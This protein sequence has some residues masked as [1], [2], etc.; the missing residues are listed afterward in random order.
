[1]ATVFREPLAYGPQQK[2]PIPAVD[3]FSRPL[4]LGINPNAKFSQL[5]DSA[6][7][8]RRAVNS[9]RYP[10]LLLTTLAGTPAVLSLPLQSGRSFDS[11][12]RKAWQAD[13]LA[14]QGFLVCP[15]APAQ[16]LVDSAPHARRFLGQLQP[17][18]LL[19]STLAVVQTAP[20]G[21]AVLESAPQTR[22]RLSVDLSQDLLGTTLLVTAATPQFAIRL[23]A[24]APQI[25]YQVRTEALYRPLT[26]GINPNA[27]ALSI[28]DSATPR[29]A[30][31]YLFEPPNL[32]ITT[33]AAPLALPL[34]A[35]RMDWSA[36]PRKR[37]SYPFDPLNRSLY[38]PPVVDPGLLEVVPYLIGD[39]QA[40]A[41]ARIAGIHCIASVTGS[42]GT[43]TAQ[44]P[45]HMTIVTR[46]TT[47]SITLG[48]TAN[49]PPRGKG[50]WPNYG[51]SVH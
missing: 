14:S 41:L 26:L 15:D 29:K 51:S 20:V 40:A 1:M 9:D 38:I 39:T 6:P 4:T 19:T 33:L 45:A 32:L 37:V 48:G 30:A 28:T 21:R 23:D 34:R 42:S 3:Y 49:N 35:L 5:S 46:G 11:A 31:A 2:R 10:N 18:N 13:P 50:G 12:P 27:A 25:K 16:S 43:V 47:I 36:T 8:A 24:P 17:P 7:A 44:D 22:R